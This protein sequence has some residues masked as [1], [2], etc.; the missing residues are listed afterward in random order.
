MKHFKVGIVTALLLLCAQLALA[1]SIPPKSLEEMVTEADHV[2]IGTVTKVDMVDGDDQPLTDPKA[3]TGPGLNNLIR[4]HVEV[5]EI[6]ES[7]AQEHPRQLV[8]PLWSAWHSS[9]EGSQEW[10]GKTFIFLLKGPDYSIVYPAGFN[11]ELDERAQIEGLLK[12][13]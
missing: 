12:N 7:P 13:R 6:L 1:T 11:R 2:I 8:V 9:L 5:K 4:L 10:K 3:R